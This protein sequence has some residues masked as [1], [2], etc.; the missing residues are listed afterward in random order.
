MKIATRTFLQISNSYQFVRV[1]DIWRS[2]GIC[3]TMLTTPVK[4]TLDGYPWV[5][6]CLS[7]VHIP[8]VPHVPAAE[9]VSMSFFT[10]SLVLA[11]TNWNYRSFRNQE[12]FIQW[13]LQYMHI[14]MWHRNLPLNETPIDGH[15]WH[16]WH[17]SALRIADPQN[18]QKQPVLWGFGAL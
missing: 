6:W 9:K 14:N 8:C 18:P 1:N 11:R 5:G 7:G 17:W 12:S 13:Y 2:C 3:G 15:E 16:S 10:S 4:F